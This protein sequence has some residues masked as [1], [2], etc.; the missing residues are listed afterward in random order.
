MNPDDNRTTL[1]KIP[2]VEERYGG[3]A[4]VS[5][6]L[7]GAVLL[8]F[9]FG[10]R[11]FPTTV[12]QLGS[13]PGGGVGGDEITTVGVVDQFSGGAGMVKPSMIPQPPAL[14]S[15]PE[16]ET[17]KTEDSTAVALPGTLE[18]PKPK[19]PEPK[20]PAPAGKDAAAKPAPLGNIIP[21]EA[22]PGSGGVA[23]MRAG[24]GGGV[25]GGNGISVGT[26]SG[27]FGDS[28]Y[29]AALEKRIG[30]NWSRPPDGIR[31]EVSYSFYIAPNGTI[32]EI[33]KEKSS[34]N[35][36]L[37]MYAERAIRRIN[38]L[39]P[40]PR[41]FRGKAVQFVAQFVHPPDDR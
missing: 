13:G 25:G 18:P 1:L 29:A 28:G 16:K 24:T 22:Q 34:G 27:G 39:P 15:P 11:L 37:D 10:S 2:L 17:P 23:G 36:T 6:F 12:V 19:K 35:P 33:K 40:L 9:L 26:G 38:N 8:L 5:L 20:K 4:A 14:P 21:T 41:E 7:H 30:D 3:S 32:Y 31:V